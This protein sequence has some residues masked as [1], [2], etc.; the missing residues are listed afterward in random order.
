LARSRH[1]TVTRI[2]QVA[3]VSLVLLDV[4]LYY[5][6]YR[7]AQALAFTEQQQFASLRRRNLEAEIRI[8]RLKKFLAAL[9]E[10]GEGLAAFEQ[11]H[12]PPRRQG[13]SKAYDLVRSMAQQSGTQ[14]ES[15]AFKL[16]SKSPGPL[17]SLGAVINVGGSFAGLLRFAHGLE[18]AGNLI[19]IRNFSIVIGDNQTLEMR[20]AIDLY[21]TP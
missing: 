8:E 14:L 10:A 6:M 13:Y 18:T 20:L 2:F 7:S 19:L 11:E 9:P 5:L 21:L 17:Q 12:T 1:Q 3:G 15:V 16:D 4:L